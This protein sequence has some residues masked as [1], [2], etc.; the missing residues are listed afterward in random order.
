MH[1][2]N[3]LTQ[4]AVITNSE[5]RFQEKIMHLH[6]YRTNLIIIFSATLSTDTFFRIWFTYREFV[7]LRFWKLHVALQERQ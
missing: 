1:R 5:Q 3:S 4:F 6:R 2:R 7:L